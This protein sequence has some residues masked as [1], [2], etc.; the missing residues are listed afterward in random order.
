MGKIHKNEKGLF[1]DVKRIPLHITI[2]NRT[3]IDNK[4]LDINNLLF[5]SVVDNISLIFAILVSVAW[6]F[7]S[8]PFFIKVSW[9]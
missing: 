1:Y 2:G 8:L 9:S 4:D 6:S 5:P 3:Y 7:V